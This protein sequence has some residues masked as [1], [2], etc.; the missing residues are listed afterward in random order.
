VTI[1]VTSQVGKAAQSIM[2]SAERLSDSGGVNAI[3]NTAIAGLGFYEGYKGLKGAYEGLT[4]TNPDIAK[5]LSFSIGINA[6]VSHQENSWS[7]SSSTPVVTDIR[8]GRSITMEAEKGSITSDGAQIL[9]GYD[10]YGIPTIPGDLSVTGNGDCGLTG[11]IFLSAANGDINLNAATGTSD[12]TSSNKSW[13]AGF[14]VNFGCSTKG[15]CQEA[16]VGVNASYG[17]GGSVV[18]R[19]H[20]VGAWTETRTTRR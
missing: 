3:T 8:A 18:S 2:N 13:S 14:G 16:G 9:A 7:S 12:S 20:P 11:D 19:S 4:S 1:S 10:K 5:G 6:G 17:K 15:G